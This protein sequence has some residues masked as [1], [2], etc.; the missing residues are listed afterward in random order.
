MLAPRGVKCEHMQALLTNLLQRCWEWQ[1]DR[2]DACVPR[3]FK[4]QT[5]CV[6]SLDVP[7]AFDVDTPSMV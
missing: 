2:R 1:E 4:C 5:A 3:F 7:T 6:A